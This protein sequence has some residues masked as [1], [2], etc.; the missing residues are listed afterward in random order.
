MNI[1]VTGAD[2]YIA[3]NV[4]ELLGKH[5]HIKFLK[6]T[7]KNVNLLD[8]NDVKRYTNENKIDII[9]HTAIEGG[10]RNEND[11]PIVFYNNVL[12]FENLVAAKNFNTKIINIG[13]GAELRK[14]KSYGSSDKYPIY[15]NLPPTSYYGL[16]KYIIANKACQPHSNA[17]SLRLY[18]CFYHNEDLNRMIRSNIIRSIKGE[19]I[20]IHKDRYMDFFY[21]EDFVEVI[22]AYISGKDLQKI[23]DICYNTHYKLSDIANM[24][25]EVSSKKVEIIVENGGLDEPYTGEGFLDRLDVK[26]KGLFQGIK[27]CYEKN[28]I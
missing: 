17:V 22:Y 3:S 27:E 16:S 1:M 20:I 12:M 26:F 24:I 2:G 28:K 7:R 23:T 11:N 10:M 21:L 4:I 14:V 25:N 13:S 18:N 6:V 15:F 8:I 9:L 5:K 19:P